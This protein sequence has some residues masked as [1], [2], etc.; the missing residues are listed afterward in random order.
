MRI[1]SLLFHDIYV[2]DPDESGFIG[3]TASH[4]KISERTFGRHLDMLDQV[5][6]MPPVLVTET[7][8]TMRDKVP[9]SFTVDDGGISYHSIIAESLESRGWRGHCFVTTGYIGKRG[10]LDKSHLRDLHARGHLIGSHSVTHRERMSLCDPQTVYREW[11]ESRKALEDILGA[12]VTCASVPG[13]Y[14]SPLVARAASEAGLKILFTSEPEPSG[15]FVGDCMVLG[16]FAVR[17]NWTPEYVKRLVANDPGVLYRERLTWKGK[18]ALK[19][20]LGKAY[21]FLGAY[22]HRVRSS[23][24]S[25]SRRP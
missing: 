18:K 20:F 12:E 16:R 4:Y 8:D 7:T 3:P 1:I 13:G 9:V 11:I 10:F 2:S 15:K 25:V 6:T 22:A 14:Y 5:L 17:K 24:K 23:I 19:A 21:P